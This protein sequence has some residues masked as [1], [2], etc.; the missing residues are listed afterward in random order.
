MKASAYNKDI[1]NQQI[2]LNLCPIKEDDDL[3]QNAKEYGS[4]L[5]IDN[6]PTGYPLFKQA[7]ILSQKYDV[8]VTNPPYMGRKSLNPTLR[9][10]IDI[11]YPDGKSELYSAFI[12]SCTQMLMP[13]T[14][15]AGTAAAPRGSPDAIASCR[16]RSSS[17]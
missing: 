13:T 4:L 7:E 1:L 12:I 17:R 15:G 9:K 11:N 8:V 5:K 6:V 3:F 16:R 10:F 14:C 2:I